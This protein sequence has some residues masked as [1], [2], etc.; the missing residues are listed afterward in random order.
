MAQ[1]DIPTSPGGPFRRRREKRQLER[2]ADE[3]G[4]EPSPIAARAHVSVIEDQTA[5]KDDSEPDGQASDDRSEPLNE[6]RPK[7]FHI[8]AVPI[9]QPFD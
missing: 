3:S 4:R 8:Y 6:G 1:G 5:L 7:G 9:D 2:L